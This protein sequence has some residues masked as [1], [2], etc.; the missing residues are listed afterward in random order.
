MAS[1][2]TRSTLGSAK[3]KPR[4]LTATL[5]PALNGYGVYAPGAQWP[6]SILLRMPGP[7]RR[8]SIIAAGNSIEPITI[9]RGPFRGE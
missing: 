8:D 4:K 3:R 7:T 5:R 6:T 2:S 1:T 9:L